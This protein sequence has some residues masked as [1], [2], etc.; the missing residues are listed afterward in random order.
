MRGLLDAG[1]KRA[2]TILGRDVYARMKALAARQGDAEPSPDQLR[3]AGGNDASLA[4]SKLKI[5]YTGIVRRRLAAPS[6][7]PSS[8]RMPNGVLERVQAVCSVPLARDS[9]AQKEDLAKSLNA[10]VDE[11]VSS[12]SMDEGVAKTKVLTAALTALNAAGR[13]RG[14]RAM[15]SD[16]LRMLLWRE[17]AAGEAQPQKE[18]ARMRRK[19]K[20]YQQAQEADGRAMSVVEAVGEAVAAVKEELD[21]MAELSPVDM[22]QPASSARLRHLWDTLT[23]RQCELIAVT[24]DVI[25][26]S[27]RTLT[28]SIVVLR[29]EIS[30]LS[31]W[32]DWTRPVLAP[33]T[34]GASTLR[35]HTTGASGRQLAVLVNTR[36]P[37]TPPTPEAKEHTERTRK[38]R[39]LVAS[40]AAAPSGTA[41]LLVLATTPPDGGATT[42]TVTFGGDVTAQPLGKDTLSCLMRDLHLGEDTDVCLGTIV[43]GKQLQRTPLPT[44]AGPAPTALEMELAE[45]RAFKVTVQANVAALGVAVGGGG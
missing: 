26:D 14:Q 7:A 42:A 31:G 19:E 45:L 44:V 10:L 13:A 9:A 30:S 27:K 17:D 28:E 12:N 11:C 5:V 4:V 33:S 41:A 38:V 32:A 24:G 43:P 36:A 6:V 23:D 2:R 8:K 29:E 20:D 37:A 1:A 25:Y 39:T 16:T 40:V 35:N 34:P 18:A 21:E 15:Q 3:S 22:A